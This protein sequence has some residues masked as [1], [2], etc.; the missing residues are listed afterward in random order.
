MRSWLTPRRLLSLTLVAG[1]VGFGVV[2]GVEAWWYKVE[3]ARADR[4]LAAGRYG[5]ALGRL[6][7][8]ST[9]W[10]GRAEV[11][12]PRGVCEAALGH[13]DAA[14]AAWERVPRDSSLG[15]RAILDRAR[16]AA[17]SWPAR[18]CRG[19]RRVGA[20][21]PERPRSGGGEPG[22]SD[23]PLHRSPA[24]NPA[25]N[26]TAL[27]DLRDQAGLLRL[28]WQLDTQPSLI[29]AIGERLQRMAR[30]APDDD[31]VL[32][33]LADLA[34]IQGR[35]V[36]ADELLRKCEASRAADPDVLMARLRWALD[37][38]HPD[39]AIS[40]ASN[41][42]ANQVSPA[43][44]AGLA[45]RLAAL[46]GTNEQKALERRVDLDPGDCT[47]WDR[48]AELAGRGGETERAARFRRRKTEIGR[49]IDQYRMLMGRST[50]SDAPPA[51]E[52]A[53]TAEAL[54]RQFEAKGWWTIWLCQ[55]ADDLDA[56]AALDR[57]AH[58]QSLALPQN[59]ALAELIVDK[60]DTPGRVRTSRRACSPSQHFA[61]TLKRRASRSSTTMTRHHSAGFPRRWAAAW[62]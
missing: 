13:V 32:L 22:R 7:R 36:E 54:G 14:L 46:R 20:G 8:L 31:R 41:L 4:E 6:E 29:L 52:L 9:R 50:G 26:R 49:A 34:T 27:A 21:R 56:C 12:Y 44:A 25:P 10:T 15:G 47:A 16:L 3:L 11:E 33:G 61:T 39:E 60:H 43:E 19:K 62:A 53:R 58:A 37:A 28:H 59:L 24:C 30:E 35:Y 42:P 40:A 48:L 57:L 23:R 1:A 2:E 51:G 17:G 5:Q 38:E 45:A 18:H 55:H